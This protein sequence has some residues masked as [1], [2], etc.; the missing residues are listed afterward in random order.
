MKYLRQICELTGIR[1]DQANKIAS[2]HDDEADET[3]GPAHNYHKAQAKRGWW[4]GEKVSIHL[5]MMDRRKEKRADDKKI[6]NYRRM[7]RRWKPK[8]EETLGEDEF[9]A[10]RSTKEAKLKKKKVQKP[11]VQ[12][13]EE[14]KRMMDDLMARM[15][16]IGGR[17]AA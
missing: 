2:H 5:D 6:A 7:A 11:Y 15:K 3:R 14:K 8:N 13:P 12:S 4:V 10:T 1:K 9:S 17:T 16:A